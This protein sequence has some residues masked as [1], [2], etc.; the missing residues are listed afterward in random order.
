MGQNKSPLL[1][2]K[3]KKKKNYKPTPFIYNL[4]YIGQVHTIPK[5]IK[6]DIAKSI[7][8]LSVSKCGQIL[9]IDTQLN[10][11]LELKGI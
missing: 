4:W 7:A 1:R 5:F 10:T 9:G 8:Q 11:E 6:K 3:K 2:M